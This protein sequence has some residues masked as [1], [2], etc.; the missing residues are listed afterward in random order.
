MKYSFNKRPSAKTNVTLVHQV[1]GGLGNQELQRL[2]IS[3]TAINDLT[4]SYGIVVRV[5]YTRTS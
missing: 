4:Y 3:T 2:F 1:L 5:K